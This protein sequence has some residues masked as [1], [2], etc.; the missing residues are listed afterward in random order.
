MQTTTISIRIPKAEVGRL[1]RLAHHLGM[2]RPSFLKQALKRGTE[3]LMFDGACQAYRRGQATLSRAAEMAELSLREM[4]LRMEDAD[5]ELNYDTSDLRKDRT[6]CVSHW[7]QCLSS[8]PACNQQCF[9]NKGAGQESYKH[10]NIQRK[11]GLQRS[12]V[13]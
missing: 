12:F 8:S 7:H 13:V 6:P 1:D 3:D 11:R 10:K 4:I 9:L 2:E 5:L